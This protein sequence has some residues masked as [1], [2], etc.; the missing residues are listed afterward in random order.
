MQSPTMSWDQSRGF[1]QPSTMS[2]AG[3]A[4]STVTAGHWDRPTLPPAPPL[5]VQSLFA[6]C[7]SPLLGNAIRFSSIDRATLCL[8]EVCF[9]PVVCS[10]CKTIRAFNS[11]Q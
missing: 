8:S 6:L 1:G 7:C 11:H 3:T 10:L 4:L 5:S 9:F 2:T